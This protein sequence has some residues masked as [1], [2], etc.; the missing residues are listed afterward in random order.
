MSTHGTSNPS[1]TFSAD[2]KEW[3]D[4]FLK[5]ATHL[6]GA[7]GELEP[8]PYPAEA[9]AGYRAQTRWLAEGKRLAREE[10]IKRRR[11]PLLFRNRIAELDR[12][13]EFPAGEENFLARFHGIF[14]VAPVQE[15]PMCRMRIPGGILNA[16][17]ARVVS[18][19]ARELCDGVVWLTTRSNLQVR[20]IAPG[21]MNEAL[22][23]LEECGLGA[24]G[25]GADS[26]RN[27]VGNPTAGID[28]QELLDV[29][30][31]CRAWHHHVLHSPDLHGLPRKFNVAFDGGG[32]IAA[33]EET[34]DIGL[35]AC[36]VEGIE[37]V[38]MRLSLGGITGH[39]DFAR[40]SQVILGLDEWLPALDA[41]LTVFLENANR[42]QR[43][44]ARLKYLLDDWGFEYFL[45]KVQER[46]SFPLRRAHLDACRFAPA[47]DRTAHLGAHPQSDAGKMWLGVHVPAGRLS[48]DQFQ[49]V[50]NA[51]G[52]H[53]DGDIRLTVWQNILISGIPEADLEA[54]RRVLSDAGLRTDPDGI[55][56]GLVACTGSEG[57]KHGQAATKST[58]LAIEERL[59]GRIPAE[60]P[61]NI[62]LTGCPNS[63]AQHYIGDI[64]LLGTGIEIEGIR[65][66]AFHILV[67]GGSGRD[68]R[69]AVQIW[70]SVPASEVPGRIESLV[71]TWL[72]LRQEGETFADFTR[73]IGPSDLPAILAQA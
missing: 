35:R 73:R 59:T 5:A 33:L 41:I 23:R 61:V 72:A 43:S 18:G 68:A 17:Q 70:N 14:N 22:L 55:L 16:Q 24:K 45:E 52:R 34:N 13:G 62:H 48:A 1:S 36:H 4:G 57:C 51:A 58:A 26:I 54:V 30:P 47:I 56:Q 6:V 49:A 27:V 71:E 11:N 8:C 40:D 53:G 20:Q 3:L 64:G 7:G 42:G 69:C 28:P 25:S 38:Q 66:D 46:L 32:M 10:D 31:L 29:R 67:G 2:Q 50:A 15:R 65:Q 44:K 60:F 63:C 37:G 39:G 19:I 9:S 12:T 21:S